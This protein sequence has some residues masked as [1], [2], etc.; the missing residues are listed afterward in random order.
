M[1][2]LRKSFFGNNAPKFAARV[3]PFARAISSRANRICFHHRPTFFGSSV[4]QGVDWL[5]GQSLNCTLAPKVSRGLERGPGHHAG[6][7]FSQ[8]SWCLLD[9][10]LGCA[11]ARE[12][13]ESRRIFRS[14][15]KARGE[16]FNCL[17]ICG[18]SPIISLLYTLKREAPI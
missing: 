8:V 14:S 11:F 5:L 6:A 13:Q 4:R 2:F 15:E 7:N 16:K 18:A 10:K 12:F 17:S 9:G 3:A 1:R